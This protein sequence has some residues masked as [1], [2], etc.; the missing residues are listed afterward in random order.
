MGLRRAAGGSRRARH[1]GTAFAAAC[2]LTEIIDLITLTRIDPLIDA[3]RIDEALDVANGL[4]AR[5]EVEAPGDLL[6]IRGAQTRIHTLRGTAAQVAGGLEWLAASARAAENA[7]A[8]VIGLASA[9][10]AHAALAHT[11]SAIAT[12]EELATTPAAREPEYYTANLPALVRS[13]V[14]LDDDA[15]AQRL[16][17]GVEP[18]NRYAKHTLITATA[19]IA[20][21]TGDVPG[22]VE[23]YADAAERWEQFGVVPEHAYALLGHGRCLVSLGRPTEAAPVLRRARELFHTLGATPGIAETDALLQHAVALS[24]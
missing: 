18:H 9:A 6:D 4:A 7:D 20:E 24:S 10:I 2:G 17:T 19:I 12:L 8:L 21:A 5:L 13:A 23:S 11:D 16:I 1:R 15:L 3:G 14:A 22:A